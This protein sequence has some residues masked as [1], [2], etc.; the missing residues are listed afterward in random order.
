M[1]LLV[2]ALFVVVT[3]VGAAAQESPPPPVAPGPLAPPPPPVLHLVGPMVPPSTVTRWH[4]ARVL[5][6]FGTAFGL[7]GT[8]LSLTSAIYIF[9]TDYPPSAGDFLHPASPTDTAQVLSYAASSTSAV[10]F[11]LS[12]G[13]LAWQHHILDDL[14]ADTGRGLFVGG[15]VI[16]ILGLVGVGT[17]YFFGLTDYL[18]AHDQSIAVLTTSLGGALLCTIGSLL[19][20]MDSGRM[21]RQWQSITAF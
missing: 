13:G 4:H 9:A 16:G 8:A 19:Y 15:T 3:S 12:A 10:G 6:G 17:G 18:N 2:A 14:G 7:V 11:S 5:E 1:R 21:K 20:G